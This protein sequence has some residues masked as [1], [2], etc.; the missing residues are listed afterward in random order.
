MYLLPAA[1]GLVLLKVGIEITVQVADLQQQ[2]SIA[3]FQISQDIHGRFQ[4]GV[5][6]TQKDGNCADVDRQKPGKREWQ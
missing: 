3:S 6:D 5:T 1:T 4:V 2:L